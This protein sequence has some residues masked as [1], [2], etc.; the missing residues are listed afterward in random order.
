MNI[1]L[2]GPPGAGKGTQARKIEERY[3]LKQLSTGDMLR[4]EVAAG[5]E[6]GTQAKTIMDEGGL[7]SDDIIIGMVA[8]RIEQSDCAKGVIFDGF[9]RTVE[10]AKA[11]D[12]LLADKGKALPIIIELE[13]NEDELVNRLNTRIQEAKDAG[14]PVRSDD[15]EDTLRNRLSVYRKDTAP[16]TPY[17]KERNMH[18]GINGM[19]AIEEVEAAINQTLENAK[20]A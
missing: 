20:A 16:I 12:A 8:N 7:V 11:L 4:A 9:P 18:H 1:I 19:V 10:Q 6:L 13:V 3:G 5:T 2:L 15:N 17:Y 14:Q